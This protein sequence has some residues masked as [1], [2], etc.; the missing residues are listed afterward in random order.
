MVVLDTN[1]LSEVMKEK[2][3]PAVVDW[4]S[5]VPVETM[6]T[7]AISQAEI[8]YGVRRLPE[9]ARRTRLITAAHDL[10]TRTFAGRILPFDDEAASMLADI[11]ISRESAGRPI[12][13]EDA[14][15][16]AIAMR[17]GVCVATRDKRGF[18][19]CGITIVDPWARDEGEGGQLPL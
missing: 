18:A 17:N 1:V 11:R 4:L 13:Q 19:G 7:T 5:S 2:P 14:M 9:G 3:D 12:S 15:I 8:L 16:A 10:F 6:L